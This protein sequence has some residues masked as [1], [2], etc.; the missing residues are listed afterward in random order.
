MLTTE[1][2]VENIIAMEGRAEKK[3]NLEIRKQNLEL[4]NN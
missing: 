3:W 1:R 2:F 4:E